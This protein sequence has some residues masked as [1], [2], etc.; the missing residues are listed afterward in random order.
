MS[1]QH[2]RLHQR[3]SYFLVKSSIA[4]ILISIFGINDVLAISPDDLKIRTSGFGDMRFSYYDY[5]ANSNLTRGAA[6]DSRAD[7]DSTRF[8][9]KIEGFYIPHN[10]EF[11]AEVEFEH[12]GTGAA[13][14]L[15]YDESGEFENEVEKGGEVFLEEFYLKKI[16]A[17][18]LSAAVGRI[19]VAFGQL[20]LNS[21]P[22]D[23]LAVRRPETE[24][25][26]IPESWNEMGIELVH[27][28]E[29]VRFHVQAVNGLDSSGFSSQS[30][31]AS[32]HQ[33]KFEEVKATD[34]AGVIRGDF[35]AIPGAVVGI[36]GYY[37]GTSRNR[38]QPDLVNS[39]EKSDGTKVAPC[40]FQSAAVE[41]IDFH[42]LISRS[43]FRTTGAAMLGKLSNAAKVSERNSRLPNGLDAPR[44]P[45]AASA[46]GIWGEVGYDVSPLLGLASIHAL[47]PF[48]RFDQYDT[49]Y[50][51]AEGQVDNPRY[52]QR[53]L[54]GGISYI[55]DHGIVSKFDVSTR[56]FG[57]DLL[58][59]ETTIEAGF[60]FIF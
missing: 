17:S 5:G 34:L 27:D 56:S 58:R 45:V 38:P 29:N 53:I 54:T 55:L 35:L 23:Y 50:K 36:S 14:E 4:I 37:G 47:E 8:S 49:V 21:L 13:K 52:A 40:G 3:P 9:A 51:I 59:P 39:C 6:A 42:W 18:S 31:V 25:K 32:G 28:G 33:G 60:S 10:I 57:S 26:V 22:T 1:Q 20:S 43:S 7:F 46:Y 48:I 16:W 11:E 41:L 15:E 12:G 19:K 44:S 24:S 30:W 2:L